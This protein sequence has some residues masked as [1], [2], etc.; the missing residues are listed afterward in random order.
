MIRRK[1]RTK[2][3]RI[4]RKRG[5]D[6]LLRDAD[7]L[8]LLRPRGV[9]VVLQRKDA[10]PVVVVEEVE[11]LDRVP[12]VVEVQWISSRVSPKSNAFAFCNSREDKT[13]SLHS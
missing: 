12:V 7:A 5:E 4:E 6:T 9:D 3:S 8:H 11:A 1:R 2:T 10:Q 13:D